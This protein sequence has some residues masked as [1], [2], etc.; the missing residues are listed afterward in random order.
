[1]TFCSKNALNGLFVM[2][3]LISIWK[4]SEVSLKTRQKSAANT[5]KLN[6]FTSNILLFL[7][8]S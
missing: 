6:I 2:S 8:E 1:M 5:I 7:A 3:N 4:F